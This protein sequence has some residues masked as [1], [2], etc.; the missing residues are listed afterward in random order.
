MRGHITVLPSQASTSQSYGYGDMANFYI[1][2]T[3][4][5]LIAFS[6]FGLVVLVG[7]LVVVSRGTKKHEP[8]TG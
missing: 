3:G 6:A 8:N 5:E 1:L 7:L 4:K 2:V